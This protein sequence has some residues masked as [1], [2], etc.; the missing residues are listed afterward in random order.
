MA[1]GTAR[2]SSF[3]PAQ[4]PGGYDVMDDRTQ[5]PAGPALA[6]SGGRARMRRSRAHVGCAEAV[7]DVASS[8]HI[9]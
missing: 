9:R 3:Y 1:R 4:H 6:C 7:E 8:T 5:A 2:L